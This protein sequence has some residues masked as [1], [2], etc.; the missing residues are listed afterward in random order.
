MFELRI[1]GA[2]PHELMRNLDSV[3]REMLA[4]LLAEP[5]PRPVEDPFPATDTVGAEAQP[6]PNPVVN[7]PPKKRGR[8]PAAA[9][10]TIDAEPAAAPLETADFLD[11]TTAVPE[12]SYTEADCREA[13][14]QTLENFEAR[15][16]VAGAFES[17]GELMAAKIAWTKP[18]LAE[19]NV[20]K[21]SALKPEQYAAFMRAAQPYIDGTTGV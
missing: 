20:A 6:G 2:T 4:G 21:V 17:E 8:K 3:A 19:F 7:E 18:L 9:P 5:T 15:A 13:V 12:V 16:R 14:R 1:V 11:D 10:V